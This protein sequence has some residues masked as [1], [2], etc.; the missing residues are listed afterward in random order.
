MEYRKKL[1]KVN[2][3][4]F[5]AILTDHPY[6]DNVEVAINELVIRAIECCYIKDNFKSLYFNFKKAYLDEGFTQISE[7]EVLY[8]KYLS[9]KAKYK[10]LKEYYPTIINYLAK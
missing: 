1:G 6:G 8:E 5:K 7:L 2:K 9:K 10:T 3:E 4:K